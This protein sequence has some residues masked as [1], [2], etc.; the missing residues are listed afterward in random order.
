[1]NLAVFFILFFALLLIGVPIY[2][3]MLVPSILYL[4]LNDM[5]LLMLAQKC[6][7]GLNSFTLIA[8]PFFIMAAQVM[9]SG[10]VTNRIFDFC[11]SLVGHFKGGLGYVNVLASVIFSGMSGSAVADVGGLG[12]VEIKAMRDAGYDESFTIGVTAASGTIGP[13]IPPSIPFVVYANY[14]GASTGAL[15]MAGILPGVFMAIVLCF[16]CRF[17]AVKTNS[18]SSRRATL[19]EMLQSFRRSILAMLMPLIIIGGI[20]TGVVTPTEAALVAIVYALI[21]SGLI[22]RELSPKKLFQIIM[23]TIDNTMPIMLVIVAATIFSFIVSYERLDTI[24][25]N[26]FTALTSSPTVILLCIDVMVLILGMFFDCTVIVMLLTPLLLPLAGAYGLSMTHIGVIVVLNAMI[27]LLTPPVGYSLYVL[28]S[29]TGHPV[30]KIASWCMP[31][32]VPL[33]LT[34]LAITVFP[35]ISLFIPTLL[36]IA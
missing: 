33:V 20:W 2:M 1:M 24:L 30:S 25:F 21:V 15:F 6:M 36:G 13:I 11:R 8:I 26:F 28:N 29:V 18:P 7:N 22:Y 17:M 3:S 4:V 10:S 31:W 34:L 27:G 12:Q 14:S 35:Q 23:D 19:R 9:N 5:S 32:M 16:M